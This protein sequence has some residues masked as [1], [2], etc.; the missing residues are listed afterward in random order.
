MT[1]RKL[2]APIRQEADYFRISKAKETVGLCPNTIRQFIGCG[3]PFVKL[4]RKIVLIRKSDI[5]KFI[6][7]EGKAFGKGFREMRKGAA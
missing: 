7:S 6:E 4:S 3:L 2:K 1:A 5:D